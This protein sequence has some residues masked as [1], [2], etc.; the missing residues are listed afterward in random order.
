MLILHGNEA[1][2]EVPVSPASID[3]VRERCVAFLNNPQAVSERLFVVANWKFGILIGGAMSLLT[4]L[5]FTGC[6]WQAVR[7]VRGFGARVLRYV[8]GA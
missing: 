3:G 7:F 1:S 2:F 6:A 5:Y 8:S 4:V